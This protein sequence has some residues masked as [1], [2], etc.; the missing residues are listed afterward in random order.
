GR[1]VPGVVA[2]SRRTGGVARAAA[3]AQVR[4][5]GRDA[6]IDLRRAGG[7]A[8]EEVVAERAEDVLAGGSR[9]RIVVVAGTAA[10][11]GDREDEGERQTIHCASPSQCGVRC[12]RQVTSGP[13]V[14]KTVLPV[15]AHAPVQLKS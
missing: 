12:R 2:R 11:E 3:R 7:I 1:C 9:I 6:A 10:G 4:C 14:T 5:A 8:L 15:P 13:T